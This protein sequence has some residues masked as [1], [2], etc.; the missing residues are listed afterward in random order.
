MSTT[1]APVQ[2]SYGYGGFWWRFLAA[3][4]D[5]VVVGILTP[6]F[7][8][9]LP[10]LLPIIPLLIDAGYSIF[11][12]SSQTQ[13]TVGKMICRLKVADLQGQRISPGKAALRYIGKYLSALLAF[14]GYLLV[15]FTSKKQALHDLMAGT[16]VLKITE[17]NQNVDPIRGFHEQQMREQAQFSAEPTPQAVEHQPETDQQ[18]DG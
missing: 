1:Q 14:V 11:M 2:A 9:F 16:V 10:F 7:A 3:I 15:F 13:G 5:A 6:V 8:I 18:K 12:E 17:H 4:I